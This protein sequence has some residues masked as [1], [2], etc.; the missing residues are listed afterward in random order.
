MNSECKSQS[1][2]SFTLIELLVVIAIIAILAAILM[3]ALSSARERAKGSQCINNLKQCGTAI[4]SYI[5]DHGSCVAYFGSWESGVEKAQWQILICDEAKQLY[6]C[7]TKLGGKYLSSASA[8][9]CPGFYPNKVLVGRAET[10]CQRSRYGCPGKPGVH[11]GSGDKTTKA[12]LKELEMKT[13]IDD[14]GN[15]MVW[16][17]QYITRPSSYYLL[18]DSYHKNNKSQWYWIDFTANI[19]MH[20]RHNNRASILWFDG[21]ADLNSPQD[22]IVKMPGLQNLPSVTFSYAMFNNS[23]EMEGSF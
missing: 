11:P 20:A 6:R 10:N 12:D 3:P 7:K 19:K 13:C 22:A 1:R 16:R 9:L 18:A 4:A 23:L 21:H 2:I 5:D 14:K 15:G 8:T 17:P